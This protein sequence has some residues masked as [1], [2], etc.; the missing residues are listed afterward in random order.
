MS[1]MAAID[2]DQITDELRKTTRSIKARELRI[3]EMDLR[4]YDLKMQL[5]DMKSDPLQDCL[6]KLLEKMADEK[7]PSLDDIALFDEAKDKIK[8]RH[9]LLTTI[10]D[11]QSEVFKEKIDIMAD[12][13]LAKLD[14]LKLLTKLVN[15]ASKDGKINKD[16]ALKEIDSILGDI[17]D[18]SPF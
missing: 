11:L 18:Q 3:S 16:N 4:L 2:F 6:A 7:I 9:S 1:K 14:S 13:K 5:Q 8:K 10:N 12:I 17:N 15:E